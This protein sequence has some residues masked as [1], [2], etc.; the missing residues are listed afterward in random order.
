MGE[1]L[2]ADTSGIADVDG[3]NN[4]TFGYQ[5]ISNDGTSDSDITGA[6][7]FSLTLVA[8]DEGKTLKVQVSFTDDA[9]NEETLTSAETAEV[10]AAAPTE[11][12]PRPGNLT[13][14][15]NTN[16]TVTLRWDAP[17][18]ASVTGYQILRRRPTEGENK[19]LVHV[20]DTGGTATEYT[21]EDVTPG[22]SHT[23]RVKAVNPGGLS[24][25]SNYVRV[26]PLTTPNSPATGVPTIGGR[27]QVD[28]TLT[29]NVSGIA[30]ADGLTN[31]SY[32]YQWIRYDGD[33]DSAI[34]N[35]TGSSYT[36]ADPDEGNTV[37]VKVRFTDDAG[38]EESLTSEATNAVSAI[39]LQNS[40]ATGAPAITGTVEVGQT[41]SVGTTGIED[42]DGLS[43]V[44]YVYQWIRVD[45]DSTETNIPD[46]AGSTYTLVDA[47]EGKTVK[48]QVGFTDDAGNEESLVSAA[49]AAVAARPNSPATGAPTVTGTAQVGETLTTDVSGI[50]D[51]DGLNNA[52]ISYQWVSND[53]TSDTDIPGATT[54]TYTLVAADEGNTIKVRVS[55]TDNADNEERLTSAATATV[56]ARP[57]SPATGVPTI[58]GTA[59][60]GETLTADVSSIADADGLGNAT[61]SYQWVRNDGSADSDISGATGST[62]KLTNADQGKTIKVRVSFA[63]D[64][65]NDESLASQ[66]T[67]TVAPRPALTAG[68]L[69]T[70]SA[71]DG[72]EVITFELRF[73]EHLSLSYKKL[74]FHAFTVTG[75]EVTQSRRLEEGSN[76]RWEIHIQPDGDGSVTVVLPITT[77]CN[78]QGAICTRDGRMLS[79]RNELA[80]N[81]PDG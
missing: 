50:T 69:G 62:Y 20:D 53:G 47:D 26:T 78:A 68:F 71:H 9:G 67:A 54:S 36:L 57:N 12:P 46:A 32:S 43:N 11:A 7:N 3:L 10:A 75:G 64:R 72:Q 39:P 6:T 79:N 17:E 48:V 65:D 25:R 74:K 34:Q 21:D 15:A 55:F 23:Y 31:A 24:K 56:A 8:A 30:D 61:F 66:A 14:T 80:V 35:A 70:P 16:G 38:N 76:I 41:L 13:G 77:N 33:A 37:K 45:T 5:W 58:G 27:A 22:V 73:S 51:T 2:T 60:V 81:G 19:L 1:T 49:T 52:T 42:D 63:D 29:A 4:A 28:E 40:P 59:Q 44:D 18:D